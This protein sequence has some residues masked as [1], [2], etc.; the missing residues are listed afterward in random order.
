MRARAQ[1]KNTVHF[2]RIRV[3]HQQSATPLHSELLKCIR[4][5]NVYSF[6]LVVEIFSC[7]IAPRHSRGG[8][9]LWSRMHMTFFPAKSPEQMSIKGM[10]GVFWWMRSVLGGTQWKKN[11]VEQ[12]QR[13]RRRHQQNWL[14]SVTNVEHRM[15]LGIFIGIHS[16]W[17]FFHN[18]IVSSD[19]SVPF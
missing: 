5:R 6:K 17:G 10:C 12:R 4:Y 3:S 1:K 2:S 8:S 15:R 18:F 19:L 9:N 7:K 16:S 13:R 14:Q 11:L